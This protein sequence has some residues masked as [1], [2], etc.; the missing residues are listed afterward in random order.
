MWSGTWQSWSPDGPAR[1][2]MSRAVHGDP[3]SAAAG[4][5]DY[6]RQQPAGLLAVITHA[7]EGIQRVVHGA[8][9]ASIVSQSVVPVLV[10]P[11]LANF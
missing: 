8:Q 9:A 2:L 1:R 10:V 6:L 4:I 5:G 3:I 11:H 7:R